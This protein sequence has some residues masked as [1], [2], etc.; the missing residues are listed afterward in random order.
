MG[1]SADPSGRRRAPRWPVIPR[2]RWRSS[3]R[4]SPSAR[5]VAVRHHDRLPLPLRPAHHRARLHRG[6]LPDGLVPERQREVPA[7]DPVLR[8]ALP[9]QLRDRRRDGDRP[10]V[11]V[12][13]ELERLHPLRGRH[14]R[15]PARHRGPAGLL[16]R[17][18][19]PRASGSS[20]GTA[21]PRGS[22]WRR[23]GSPRS[24]RS[25]RPTSSWPRTRGCRTR[26][27]TRSTR[28]RAARS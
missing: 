28:P 20:A 22:T 14:L 15:G 24:A 10:G 7:P 2:S 16:P 4:G 6:R 8:E 3:P 9:H 18:D 11:P 23:S 1:R 17:I 19:V 21:S 5:P 13:D 12:R 27:A 25:C 26:S